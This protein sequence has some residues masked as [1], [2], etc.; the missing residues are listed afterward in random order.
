M[1]SAN[2]MCMKVWVDTHTDTVQ[3]FSHKQ[4]C[5]QS[6]T[7]YRP[8]RHWHDPDNGPKVLPLQFDQF[9]VSSQLQPLCCPL[10]LPRSSPTPGHA[11]A[12]LLVAARRCAFH[13]FSPQITAKPSWCLLLGWNML[14]LLSSRSKHG[15]ERK[16][17][18]V[19]L[20]PY[21]TWQQSLSDMAGVWATANGSL[22]L[23]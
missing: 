19:C 5:T 1:Q 10:Q 23:F 11:D 20:V 13:P 3:R 9:A 6:V 7:N 22:S 17:L 21:A 4:T 12:S 2:N 8:E 16:R 15:Q 18:T 14:L